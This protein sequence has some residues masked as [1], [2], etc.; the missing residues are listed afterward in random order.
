MTKPHAL[1]LIALVLALMAGVYVFSGH[2]PD[3]AALYF[4]RGNPVQDEALQPIVPLRKPGALRVDRIRLGQQL[5]SDA[6]LSRDG[7]VSCA[8]CHV[9]AAGGTDNRR[10]SVGIGGAL[11]QVNAPS[12]LN[13]GLSFAQFWDGRA[14]TLELQA[15]GPIHN[16]AEMDSSWSQVVARLNEDAALRKGFQAAYSDGL[17]AQN[18]ASAL[19]NFE[20]SLVTVN[21]RFDRYLLGD[22][23]ALT[24]DELSGYKRFRELGCSSCHQGVLIGGNMFQKFGV[25]GDYFANRPMVV[26]DLGRFNVTGREEDR[27]VFKVPSLRNVALTAPYFHDGSALTLAE[28]IQVMGRYQLGR[29]LEHEDVRLIVAFLNSLTAPD[30]GSRVGE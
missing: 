23:T 27:H 2:Q 24:E 26:A 20:R 5:F 9:L 16:P 22:S 1:G 14:A 28:A 4:N 10:V 8:S 18:I 12:V 6:R 13:S 17:T 7:T 11:G 19:A 25:L 30:L 15:A 21:S 29:D 3:P